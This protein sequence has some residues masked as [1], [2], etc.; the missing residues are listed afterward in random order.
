M[1]QRK[2]LPQPLHAFHR[3]HFFTAF[4]VTFSGQD[5]TL[6]NDLI[7]KKGSLT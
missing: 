2:A 1:E 5:Q 3:L 6:L 7:F 4:M